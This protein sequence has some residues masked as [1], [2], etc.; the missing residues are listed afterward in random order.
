MR[1]FIVDIE[2]HI[3][4]DCSSIDLPSTQEHQEHIMCTYKRIY[5]IGDEA[6]V[7]EI[8]NAAVDVCDIVLL[9]PQCDQSTIDT[10][11]LQSVRKTFQWAMSTSSYVEVYT[12]YMYFIEHNTN[13]SAQVA[14]MTSIDEHTHSQ[15]VCAIIERLQYKYAALVS[16]YP[17]YLLSSQHET[18]TK[19]GAPFFDGHEMPIVLAR[20]AHLYDFKHCIVKLFI[21]GDVNAQLQLLAQGDINSIDAHFPHS[22]ST[23]Y[24]IFHIYRRIVNINLLSGAPYGPI[25]MA[26][27]MLYKLSND[28]TQE[29]AHTTRRCAEFITYAM[30]YVYFELEQDCDSSEAAV[31]IVDFDSLIPDKRDAF[32]NYAIYMHNDVAAA[33]FM[34]FGA[35]QI[36][37]S[38]QIRLA[39]LQSKTIY[40]HKDSEYASALP[41]LRGM[42]DAQGYIIAPIGPIELHIF[43]YRG[44]VNMRFVDETLYQCQDAYNML[45]ELIDIYRNAHW[46]GINIFHY[47]TSVIFP[48]VMARIGG[49][50][51]YI[52][53]RESHHSIGSTINSLITFISQ[54]RDSYEQLQTHNA[55]LAQVYTQSI[56]YAF[57]NPFFMARENLRLTF[58]MTH[59]GVHKYFETIHRKHHML[60]GLYNISI[61]DLCGYVATA[62]LYSGYKDCQYCQYAYF[63]ASQQFRCANVTH[64][65]LQLLPDRL[66]KETALL[67][68]LYIERIQGR[69]NIINFQ[70][71]GSNT[72]LVVDCIKT[73]LWKRDSF[74]KRLVPVEPQQFHN[75]LVRFQSPLLCECLDIYCNIH[76]QSIL[77]T[78]D[79]WRMQYDDA[80][81]PAVYMHTSLRLYE[82][83]DTKTTNTQNAFKTIISTCTSCNKITIQNTQDTLCSTC[84]AN[85]TAENTHHNLHT[86]ATTQIQPALTCNPIIYESQDSPQ[87]RL[88]SCM[89]AKRQK[90][91]YEPLSHDHVYTTQTLHSQEQEIVSRL[92]TEC[93]IQ[94]RNNTQ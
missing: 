13:L 72:E 90:L 19:Y 10:E 33:A 63:A 54:V 42:Y 66:A 40:I 20:N 80:Y 44:V 29:E 61:H 30:P 34:R 64:D 36:A 56:Q 60:V 74:A 31:S 91:N 85:S 82:V 57:E 86:V 49:H 14:Y 38:L 37:Y 24:N 94:P 71:T 26:V 12:E 50:T 28:T 70:C 68:R 22:L 7:R 92:H 65:N 59:N 32:Y 16:W 93:N 73:E 83:R 18:Y 52:F 89:V 58:S 53:T 3:L 77:Y 51:E 84:R 9:A 1:L 67:H 11:C 5:D 25:T 55:A 23:S 75:A 35:T 47:N 15:R 81:V 45:V 62:V 4:T 43:Y 21:R 2:D 76:V 41:H 6:I 8:Y 46:M 27:H 78:K 17:I 88:E 87:D 69:I 48:R 79:I 39:E